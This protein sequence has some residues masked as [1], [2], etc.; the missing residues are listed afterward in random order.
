MEVTPTKIRPSWILILMKVFVTFLSSLTFV[1]YS[2]SALLESVRSCWPRF[3]SL[4]SP[5]PILKVNTF[6]LDSNHLVSFMVWMISKICLFSSYQE[7]DTK[8]FYKS[9][10][11]KCPSFQGYVPLN[12]NVKVKCSKGTL[13]F[14]YII[15]HGWNVLKSFLN[16]VWLV[17]SYTWNSFGSNVIMF[18]IL[19]WF[20]TRVVHKG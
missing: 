18:L 17:S 9:L 5:K 16:H 10:R 6:F 19:V 1:T 14:T 7:Y 11:I 20:V 4:C 3:A 15:F 8:V 13:I 2:F 12:P